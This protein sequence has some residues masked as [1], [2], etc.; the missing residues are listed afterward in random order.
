MTRHTDNRIRVFIDGTLKNTSGGT[1]ADL[2]PRYLEIGRYATTNYLN[3]YAQSIRITKGLARYTATFTPPT[4][5][6]DG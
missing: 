5:E 6:F 3:G 2:V 4:A 1:Y